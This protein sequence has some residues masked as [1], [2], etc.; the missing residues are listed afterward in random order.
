MRGVR[1]GRWS[2]WPCWHGDA[3]PILRPEVHHRD[4]EDR[5]APLVGTRRT[6]ERGNEDRKKTN[7]H[8]SA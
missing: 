4:L 2:T 3:G 6:R 7:K 8:P 5:R 1:G